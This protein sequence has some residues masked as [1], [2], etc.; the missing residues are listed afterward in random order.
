[1]RGVVDVQP[2]AGRDRVRAEHA[3]DLVVEDLGRG[4]GERAEPRLAQAQEVALERDAE[5]RSAL[6]DLERGERVHVDPRDCTLHR[7]ADLE[8]GVA[9][10]G[11]VDPALETDLDGT[12]RP[13]LLGPAR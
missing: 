7:L 2:L 9:C 8:I 4:A 11:R 12:A 1:M 5:R 6:P 13:R 3:P 10:E